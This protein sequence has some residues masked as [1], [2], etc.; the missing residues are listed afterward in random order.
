MAVCD[1]GERVTQ[2]GVWLHAVELAGF[3]DRRDARPGSSTLIVA[4]EQGILAREDERSD[5]IFDGIGI[6]LEAPVGEEQAQPVPVAMDVGQLLAEPGL[7]RD[8]STFLRQPLPELSD[9]RCAALFAGGE[10]IFG[11]F[12]PD[13]GLDSIKLGNAAQAFSGN[14]G[15]IAFVDLM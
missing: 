3:D 5:P 14:R 7:G 2:I 8:L 15:G 13:L 1:G 4:G 6:H 12:A 9:K 11:A 10:P